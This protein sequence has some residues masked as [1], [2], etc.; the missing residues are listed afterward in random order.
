MEQKIKPASIK[1]I[2]EILE[3]VPITELAVSMEPFRGDERSGV[4]KLLEAG[5]KKLLRYQ[6]ELERLYQMRCY[7]RK[8]SSYQAICGVDEAGRGPLAGPV[9]AGAVILPEK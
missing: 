9:V 3:S 7:E 2:K 6:Q 4:V 1:E 5:E 8:Y